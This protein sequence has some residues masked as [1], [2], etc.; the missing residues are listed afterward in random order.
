VR[1]KRLVAE[2]TLDNT[3]LRDAGLSIAIRSHHGIKPRLSATS[4]VEA[5]ALAVFYISTET[6]IGPHP[7][8]QFSRVILADVQT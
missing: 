1:L 7:A 8:T 4:E 2:L 3:M 5:G 6:A